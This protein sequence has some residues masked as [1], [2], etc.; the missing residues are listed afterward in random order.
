MQLEPEIT[1]IRESESLIVVLDTCTTSISVF[2]D[3][4]D[5]AAR[6]ARTRLIYGTSKDD[7]IGVIL[8]GSAK[9]INNLVREHPSGYGGIETVVPPMTRSLRAVK[10]LRDAPQGSSSSNLLNLMDVCGDYL[11]TGASTR[12]KK[13]RIVLCTDGESIISTLGSADMEDFESCCNLY[14]EVGIRVDVVCHCSEEYADKLQSYE[15]EFS[16]MTDLSVEDC[17]RRC[18]GFGKSFLFTV[19]KATGGVMMPFADASPLADKPI[20]KTKRA[21]AKFRGVLNIA[22]I[23]KIPVRRY[24]HAC[25]AKHPAGKKLSW[26]ASS[27]LGEP[28]SVHVETQRVA[29]ARD[30]SPLETEEIVNAYPYGPDLVPEQN[31]IDTCAW[32]IHLPR[33]LDVIAFVPQESIPPR[34]FLGQVEVVVAMS[35]C[36]GANLLMKSIVL[37]MQ[38]DKVGMLARSVTSSKG[39][40]PTLAY[41]WPRVEAD[42]DRRS[43]RNCFLLY[44]NLPMREDIRELPFASLGDVLE[45]VPTGADD[46]MQ[47]YIAAAMLD[48][49]G[50]A[51]SDDDKD[52]C[53]DFWPHESCNPNLDWFNICIVHRA[54]SGTSGSD[55]PPLSEWHRRIMDPS[56]FRQRKHANAFQQAISD[57]KGVLP[58][59]PVPQREKKGRK[60]YRALSGELASIVD[61]LPVDDGS[62]A[63]TENEDAERIIDVPTLQTD[64]YDDI[65]STVTDLN[66]LDVRE[67]VPVEDF[68]ELVKKGHFRFAALSLLIVVRRLI[69]EVVDDDKAMYCLQALRKASIETKEPRLF[70]DFIANLVE[71]CLRLDA[72]GNRT[73]AFFRH[74]GRADKIDSTLDVIPASRARNCSS[75]SERDRDRKDALAELS[76]QIRQIGTPNQADLSVSAVSG[77]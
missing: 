29:S 16:T 24:N 70:N 32:S 26:S 2:E 39:G 66:V 33:G 41:L 50:A 4:R 74:V 43:I 11:S 3:L 59:I 72:S 75:E 44:V 53:E 10:A 36:D 57:L 14:R 45:N 20:G 21:V 35:G 8:S 51:D 63:P 19:A 13:R 62:A 67:E 71:R 54:L 65:S 48:I 38:A 27:K 73:A 23:L 69:R 22:N 49:D 56:S 64:T 60:V 40:S 37:A 47:R 25:E 55:L 28:I 5:F 77:S 15:E 61:Y 68:K 6:L 76:I 12:S 7:L 31:E 52:D 30:D 42:S 18:K 9:T 46:A 58:V 1:P 34:L 17:V